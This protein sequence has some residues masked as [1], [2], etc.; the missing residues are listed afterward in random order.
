MYGAISGDILGSSYEFGNKRYDDYKKVPI[1]HKRDHF[2][3]NTVLTLAVADWL[4]HDVKHEYYND[5][6]LRLL[7][8]KRFVKWTENY[9]KYEIAYGN[10]Y[11]QW[12]LNA[13]KK[14]DY[15][16]CNSFGNGSAMRVSPVAW[17]F[18]T[19]E[20]TLRFAKISADV[21]HNHPDGENGAMCI[22]AA[23]YLARN[24][25]SK[26]YI[27]QYLIRALGYIDLT[28]SLEELRREHEWN[29]ICKN[30]V[31]Q[32]VAAF[33]ESTDFE[34]A[35]KLAISFGGDSDIIAAMAG[36]IAECYYGAVPDK[37][38]DYVKAKLPQDALA[39]CEEF[40]NAIKGV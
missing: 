38:L 14:G 10:T 34:S 30:T 1:F 22:A 3:D 27:K 18:D 35:I 17:Y 21:T 12:F 13:Y 9:I 20:E 23:C 2:T 29:C 8:A 19:L 7:L 15:T 31:P 16:P 40:S 24:G 26:E 37:I 25:K 28:K 39:L 36:S 32:A 4:L 5:N 11:S 33:W 6:V